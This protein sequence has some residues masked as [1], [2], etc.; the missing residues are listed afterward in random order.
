MELKNFL[1]NLMIYFLNK[2]YLRTFLGSTVIT[3]SANTAVPCLH[4]SSQINFVKE[5]GAM[6]IAF[7]VHGQGKK[8]VQCVWSQ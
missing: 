2:N 7:K 3:K 6:Q 1:S 8:S 5:K 4:V